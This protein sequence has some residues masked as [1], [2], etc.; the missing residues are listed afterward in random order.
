MQVAIIALLNIG[1]CLAATATWT[2]FGAGIRR[3]LRT[4]HMLRLF[5]LGMALLL[6]GSVIPI[7]L[8]IKNTF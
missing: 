1:V 7:L 3:F 2:F 8:E 5:N 4:P 6:T